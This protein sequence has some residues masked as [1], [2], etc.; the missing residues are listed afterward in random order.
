ME[1]VE[2]YCLFTQPFSVVSY[3][4]DVDYWDVSDH[5]YRVSVEVLY[6]FIR[7]MYESDDVLLNFGIPCFRVSQDLAEI[8]N[9]AMNLS[10]IPNKY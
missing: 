9:G 1:L 7:T 8:E 6:E 5:H 10:I 2:F 4:E 3:G